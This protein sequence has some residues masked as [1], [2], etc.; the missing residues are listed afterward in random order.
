MP[1]LLTTAQ[2]TLSPSLSN[3]RPARGE[4]PDRC[5]QEADILLFCNGQGGYQRAPGGADFELN[6]VVSGRA[7]CRV[8][9]VPHA[10]EVGSMLWLLPGQRCQLSSPHDDFEMWRV[11]LAQDL[12]LRTLCQPARRDTFLVPSDQCRH[13]DWQDVRRLDLGFAHIHRSRSAGLYRAG[14]G[15]VLL[16]AWET[17]QAAAP[18]D[19]EDLGEDI[20]ASLQ[21]LNRDPT[22][23]REEI[24]ARVGISP[25][26]LSRLFHNRVGTT[27][28][29]CRQRLRLQRFVQLAGE[30]R[31]TLLDAC[32]RAGFGSYAQC[33][34]VFHKALACSPRQYLERLQQAPRR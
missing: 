22:L 19:K 21:L 3:P 8:D 34:R 20:R 26:A 23:S 29:S 27:L 10:L 15:Y 1:S 2:S 13:V 6:L 11:R 5:E 4:A 33:H 7:R 14:L 24:A 30:R 31:L 25:S 16:D 28:V 18:G 12:I 17:F 9:A 32:F